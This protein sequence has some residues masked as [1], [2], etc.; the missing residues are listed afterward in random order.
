[1][2]SPST[3]TQLFSLS[4]VFQDNSLVGVGSFSL[5][6]QA[7]SIVQTSCG[8]AYQYQMKLKVKTTAT[9]ISMQISKDL[10]IT[11]LLWTVIGLQVQVG[12][13]GFLVSIGAA[14]CN[15]CLSGYFSDTSPDG[16]AMSCP[17]CD[18]RCL[19]CTSRTQCSTCQPYTTR[20]SNTG[21]C[22]YSSSFVNT[23][24]VDFSQGSQTISSVLLNN[25]IMSS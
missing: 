25:P 13:S 16:H 5:T 1:M 6:Y 2:I 3:A 8:Y 24:Q 7:A 12:C 20:N 9:S 4:V 11:T 14:T 17:L 22:E 10:R 23:T 19:T 15:Q 18:S 21:M